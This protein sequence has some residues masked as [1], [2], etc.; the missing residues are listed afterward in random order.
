M[1]RSSFAMISLAVVLA[2][3]TR[4]TLNNESP[5]HGGRFRNSNWTQSTVRSSIQKVFMEKL[6]LSLF[7]QAGADRAE[8][9]L[10]HWSR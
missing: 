3:C 9:K 4:A 10:R 7:G 8:W 6:S 1:F 5:R 2:G